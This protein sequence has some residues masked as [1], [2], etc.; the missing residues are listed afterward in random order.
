MALAPL[1]VLDLSIITDRL[2]SLLEDCRDNSPL[3]TATNP[4]FNIA[5]AGSAPDS[6]RAAG[7]CQ[8]SVYLFHVSQDKYQRNSPVT[9]TRERVPVIPF[10]PLSLNL[11]YLVTTYAHDNYVQEQQAMSIA[12]RCFHENS[13]VRHTVAINGNNVDE[14]FCLLMEVETA[15]ELSRLWQATTIAHRLSVVY[16]VSVVFLTPEA[17]AVGPAPRPTTFSLSANPVSLPLAAAGQVIGTLRVVR[18]VAPD[19][20]GVAGAVGVARHYDLSPAVAA[21]GDEL[22]LLGAGL[23]RPTAQNIYLL[24]PNGVEH[25][26]TAWKEPDPAPPASVLQTSSRATLRLPATVGAPPANTPSPGI[27]QLRAGTDLAPAYRSSAT[28]FSIAARVDGPPLA[29]PPLLSPILLSVAGLFTLTG[30]GFVAGQTELLL[31]TVPLTQA[32]GA[33]APGRFDI[34]PLGSVITFRAPANLPAGRYTVRVRVNGVEST[35]GRWI[36]LP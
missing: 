23:D 13:N 33:P 10:Q 21:A 24:E 15:D 7:G 34:N 30:L 29:P 22:W 25:D 14:E 32:P 3:W 17:P 35:P 2:I 18:Y 9:G 12:L 36:S 5:V 8:L 26:I 11:Y 19:A 20:A 31:D 16:K 6:V 1:G 28:P 27:Y 4:Q